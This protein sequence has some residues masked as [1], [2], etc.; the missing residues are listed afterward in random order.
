MRTRSGWSRRA[1]WTR[2]LAVDRL[3]DDLEV[4]LG[5]DEHPQAG[6]DEVLVVGDEDA[7]AHAATAWV[8]GRRAST[9]KPA[10]C[11]P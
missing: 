6:A 3:A 5:V 1:A 8:T 11:G 10:P 4:V 2:L 7:D 9:R